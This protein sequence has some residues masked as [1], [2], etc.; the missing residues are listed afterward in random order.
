MNLGILL[1]YNSKKKKFNSE[2]ELLR[3]LFACGI[4]SYHYVMSS[5]G[6]ESIFGFKYGY[7]GVEFFFI[8]TGIL[9]ARTA[10]KIRSTGE[11]IN[12][13]TVGPLTK[14]FLL[15][16]IKVFL[17]YMFIAIVIY[18]ALYAIFYGFNWEFIR[19]VIEQ[20][21]NYMLLTVGGFSV[22]GFL[23]ISVL[24]YLSAMIIGLLILFPI[25]ILHPNL[26]KFVIF[27]LI[28]IFSLGYLFMEW[29]SVAWPNQWVGITNAGLLRGLGE[30]ALGV[31]CYELI[32]KLNA[33]N[34]TRWG[35]AVIT[36]L[37]VFLILF[38]FYNIIGFSSPEIHSA[39]I[40]ILIA[41]M[42]IIVCSNQGYRIPDGNKFCIFLG[43]LSLPIYLFHPC[44]YTIFDMYMGRAWNCDNLLEITFVVGVFSIVMVLCLNI[45]K[46]Y[47][48]GEKVLGLFVKKE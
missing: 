34:L 30:M 40:L 4:L 37:K 42:T 43:S 41:F 20:I 27:P 45:L 39:S 48:F 33:T 28:A 15:N 47:H 12:S 17:P 35:T 19:E 11:Q 13:D 3:F 14:T 21:P 7:Y 32:T 26:S 9:M 23:A 1:G 38:V 6:F 16:K 29:G 10:D 2:T 18:V 36:I 31:C 46:Y 24:W 44:I 25:Y 8:I 5:G 22:N